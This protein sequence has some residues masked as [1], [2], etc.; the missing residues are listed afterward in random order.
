[1]GTVRV[2]AVDDSADT[3]EIVRRQL[4]R[5][6]M[7]VVTASNVVEAIEKLKTMDFELVVTDLKMPG[8]GGLELVRW[9]RENRPE[10]EVMVITGY[11]S[12]E[13]AVKAVKTG[14]EE[15]L[16]KPFTGEE[17]IAAVRRALEARRRRLAASSPSAVE[18]LPGL[19]GTSPPMRR[20]YR[21]ILKAA[22]SDAT[23]LVLGESGTG[24][25]IVARAIHY[26]SRRSA[27]PFVPINCG[28]IPDT[29]MESELFGHVRGAFTGATA[30]RAGFFQTADRG[31]VFLD[32]V[33]E[34]SLAGQV[35]LL[36]VLQDGEVCMVGSNRARRVDV[37]VVAA[38]NKDLLRLVK[39][40]RFREDLYYRLNVVT[41]EVPP[42]RKR[43]EDVL[44]LAAHF[45]RRFSE[46]MGR[47]VLRFSEGVVERLLSYDW[48]GNV[49]ELENLVERLVVMSDG[50]L[51]APSDLPQWLRRPQPEGRKPVLRSLAEVEREHVLAV[52]EA[53][54]GNRTRAAKILGI[55]RKTLRRKLD[56]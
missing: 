14:A 40:G 30:A 35:R 42:L 38:T 47:P 15:Y 18:T 32:E 3:L 44:L 23:V 39:Q 11:A 12:L 52:L 46:E 5:A 20:L 25:E 7:S 22:Q 24:K 17:L 36:R 1:M 55:D 45:A 10:A 48:P 50:D 13:G 27:A 31:T 41:L 33:G 16:S 4:Q 6:G 29:L 34:L 49:R 9:V 19:V 56:G 26:R 43:G 21:D 54:G 8:H 28:A 37:R 51:V 2:L 53:V